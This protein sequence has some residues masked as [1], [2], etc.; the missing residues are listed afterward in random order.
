MVHRGEEFLTDGEVGPCREYLSGSHAASCKDGGASINRGD[1]AVD[2]RYSQSVRIQNYQ[3]MISR[4]VAGT[5]VCTPTYNFIAGV[6]DND[7]PVSGE[8]TRSTLLKKRLVCLATLSPI[9]EVFEVIRQPT[10]LIYF[11][12]TLAEMPLTTIPDMFCSSL[13]TTKCAAAVAARRAMEMAVF[14]NMMCW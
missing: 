4:W 5:E 13:G 14:R 12:R 3:I 10:S 11:S 9:F 8:G 2:A 6:V 7:S 1:L